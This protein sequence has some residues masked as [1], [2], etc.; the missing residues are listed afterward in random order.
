MPSSIVPAIY[1]EQELDEKISVSTDEGWDMTEA[2][3]KQGLSVG[4]SAGAAM[5]G[6]L[7]VGRRL[8]EKGESGVIVT[9]FPDRADR[10]F[11]P[12]R[13]EKKWTW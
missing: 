11:E 1:N 10:Y 5:V 2:L 9:L 7:K 12:I 6:A 4:H 13:W 8:C 3:L